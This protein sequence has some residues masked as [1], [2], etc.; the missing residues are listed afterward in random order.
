[1]ETVEGIVNFELTMDGIN[2]SQ[3]RGF[4]FATFETEEACKAAHSKYFKDKLKILVRARW[5]IELET[6]QRVFVDISITFTRA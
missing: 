3:N 1:M 4:G 6:C 2:K 5:G